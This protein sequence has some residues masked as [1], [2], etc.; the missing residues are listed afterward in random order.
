MPVLTYLKNCGILDVFIVCVDGLKGYPHAIEVVFPQAQVQLC[1]VHLTL[2]GLNYVGWKERKL[3]AADLKTI[4]RATT[5]EQA[6]LALEAFAAKWTSGIPRLLRC[7][8][9]TS[10]RSPLLRLP[11]RYGGSTT[12]PV[13]SNRRT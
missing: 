7:G 8:S 13:W 4:Y 9:A 3:V 5:A 10:N 11:Q 6:E 2:A 1:I 12:P